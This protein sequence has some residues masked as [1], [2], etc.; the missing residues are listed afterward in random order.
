MLE[1]VLYSTT[2][3][4]ILF[5][6]CSTVDLT[7]KLDFLAKY[8]WSEKQATTWTRELLVIDQKDH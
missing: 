2:H 3:S 4:P 8:L 1:R 5:Y 7:L 6:L